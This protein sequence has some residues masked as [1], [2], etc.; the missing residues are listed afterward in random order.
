MNPHCD[1]CK[2]HGE[3]LEISRSGFDARVHRWCLDDWERAF[4]ERWPHEGP[5]SFHCSPS[6][7]TGRRP[8]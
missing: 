2:Q 5:T 7:G 6:A 1:H 4:D 3:T 8:H